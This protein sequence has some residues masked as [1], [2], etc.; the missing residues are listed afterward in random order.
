MSQS[1]LLEIGDI[2]GEAEEVVDDILDNY[3]SGDLDGVVFV[4]DA[5][6]MPGKY[7]EEADAPDSVSGLTSEAI[8]EEQYSHLDRLGDE[9]DLTIHA[10]PGDHE[11]RIDNAY[12]EVISSYENVED[13]S[14]DSIDIGDHTVVGFG[15]HEN[16]EK[17]VGGFESDEAKAN[18]DSDEV[19]EES[20]E[21][22]PKAT[23]SDLVTGPPSAM[24][25]MIGAMLGF[26]SSSNSTSTDQSEET[27]ETYDDEDSET[28]EENPKK[29]I[30]EEKYDRVNQ[31]LTDA[32]DDA[33]LLHHSVPDAAEIEGSE[34]GYV[35]DEVGYQGSVI[36]TEMVEKHDLSAYLGGHHHGQNREGIFDTEVLNPGAGNY[37]EV[38][39]ENDG[40]ADTEHFETDIWEPDYSAQAERVKEQVDNKLEHIIEEVTPQIIDDLPQEV[41]D[42]IEG[43]EM[44]PREIFEEI[45][46][47]LQAQTPQQP[48]QAPGTGQERQAQPARA[49]A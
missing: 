46:R 26:G 10:L 35:N 18:A 1:K 36:G 34:M 33:V 41:R 38:T 45:Q 29:Q 11:E 32:G 47:H 20:S 19:Y 16:R 21:E 3:D 48:Q 2:H 4:G 6:N 15:S 39:L 49:E 24:G 31:L 43:G 17:P 27:E 12:Q 42:E 23:P 22:S 9:L 13:A 5:T 14:Y 25:S 44:N 37:Y 8:L 28:T 40:V 7:I 30:Y